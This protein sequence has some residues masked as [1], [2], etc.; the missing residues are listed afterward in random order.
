MTWKAA[1]I[2]LDGTLLNATKKISG[3][4]ERSIRSFVQAGYK[5]IIATGRPPHMVDDLYP[6]LREASY[7]IYFNGALIKKKQDLFGEKWSIP[8]Q[9]VKDTI[10]FF[11]KQDPEAYLFFE[12]DKRWYANRVLSQEESTLFTHGSSAF[13]Q[14][15]LLHRDQVEEH[16][17]YKILFSRY[18]KAHMAYRRAFAEELQIGYMIG[19][20]PM[21]VTHIKASKER[22]AGMVLQ[23]LGLD[24]QEVIVFGDEYNDLGLFQLCGMP[25]AMGN[26]TEEIK[27]M[28][29]KIAL[30]HEQDGVA[31]I[32]EQLLD[33]GE[34]YDG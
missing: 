28:A 17:V 8:K 2:D 12:T 22:A 5:L 16:D 33:G 11:Q 7:I 31:V 29:K 9:A 4:N 21:E 18:S 15:L 1:I 10:D 20:N 27:R 14:P 23:D 32:L 26:A 13:V 19:G 3:R 6:V 30:S 24:P 25:I 34:V